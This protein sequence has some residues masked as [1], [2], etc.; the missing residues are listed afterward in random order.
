M[1][2]LC[3]TCGH[4]DKPSTENPGHFLIELVLWFCLLV[5]GLVYSIWRHVAAYPS[6][7][8]CGGRALC[9]LDSPQAKRF[10]GTQA[11]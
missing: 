11:A 4:I 10:L 2:K 1:K 8:N 9:P 7:G 5:P 3:L 6:C